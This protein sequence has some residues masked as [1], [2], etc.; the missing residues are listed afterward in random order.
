[1]QKYVTFVEKESLK[2][3]IIK[4]LDIIAII[5]VNK[6]RGAAH[7]ICNLKLNV[8]NEIPVVFHNSSKYDFHFIFKNLANEFK[9]KFECLAEN[10][11]KYKTFS[12][13][14]EKRSYKN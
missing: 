5:Q 1:M 8:P 11:E 2:I 10:T 6:Y 4:K 13:P 9:G 12:V 7:S 14:I 3:S